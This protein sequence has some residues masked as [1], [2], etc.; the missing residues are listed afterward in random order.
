MSDKDTGNTFEVNLNWART[1]PSLLYFSCDIYRDPPPHFFFKYQIWYLTP[2]C[3]FEVQRPTLALKSVKGPVHTFDVSPTWGRTLP[4]LM[5]FSWDIYKDPTPQFFFK[6]QYWYLIPC[7]EF[8]VQN[9]T[10]ALKSVKDLGNVFDLNPKWT[11][12]LPSLIYFL[13]D[14]YRG[15]PSTKNISNIKVDIW[16]PV[17]G[18]RCWNPHRHLC[19]LK[20]R[21]IPLT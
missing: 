20:A 2:C 21:E 10:K 17:V 13:W 12:T 5:Y 4:S 18:L 14:I 8:E 7:C 16:H 6:Y 9:P 11:R 1:L 3:G 15:H 19:Q